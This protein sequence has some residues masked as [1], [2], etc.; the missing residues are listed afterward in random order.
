M[1]Q[2]RVR[3]DGQAELETWGSEL[4]RESLLIVG[5]TQD[6]FL[7]GYDTDENPCPDKSVGMA[8]KEGLLLYWAIRRAQRLNSSWLVVGQD[9]KY[10]S[11]GGFKRFLEQYDPWESQVMEVLGCGKH[12][13]QMQPQYSCKGV[14]ENGGICGGPTYVVSRAALERLSVG[15]TNVTSFL[16]DFLGSAFTNKRKSD[17]CASCFFYLRGVPL[18][19]LP[20]KFRTKEL[21]GLS[22]ATALENHIRDNAKTFLQ[23]VTFHVRVG[24]DI[25][26]SGI[27]CLHELFLNSSLPPPT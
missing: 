22:T 11:P 16:A 1:C 7:Q 27:R 20:S 13:E 19:Q 8:C 10:I 15:G 5:G 23:E 18:T 14:V 2:G 21:H 24:K 12:T 4:P 9:D 17:I 6:D 3:G 25:V 26:P